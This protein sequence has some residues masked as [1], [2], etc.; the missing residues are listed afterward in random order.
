MQREEET[1]NKEDTTHPDLGDMSP[2]LPDDHASIH[3]H[4]QA[5]HIDHLVPRGLRIRSGRMGRP[6]RM[7]TGGM[8]RSRLRGRG[9]GFVSGREL[10]AV[11]R[12]EFRV[13]EVD[14]R[15][16]TQQKERERGREIF[17]LQRRYCLSR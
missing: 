4:D 9:E 3:R 12:C 16:K 6:G 8:G 1:W 14:W 7:R 5:T 13:G 11:G 15:E 10:G 2:T 17:S